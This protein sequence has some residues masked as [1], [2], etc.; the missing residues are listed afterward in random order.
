MSERPALEI[1]QHPSGAY[2]LCTDYG[3]GGIRLC[4]PKLGGISK[5]KKR[6]ELSESDCDELER[7]VKESRAALRAL[8]H[9]GSSND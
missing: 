5:L 3:W 9:K 8:S 1:W 7:F 2:Q 6:H 4:G